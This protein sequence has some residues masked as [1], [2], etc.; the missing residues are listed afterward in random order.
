MNFLKSFVVGMVLLTLSIIQIPAQVL[1]SDN[2]DGYNTGALDKNLVGGPNA[3]PNGSGNPWF[4]P[5]PPNF[6]VVTAEYGVT[7]LSG[8]QM[9]RGKY[10]A[11]DFDQD[12]YNLAYR[13]G[14]GNSFSGNVSLS[15]NFYDP[16]GTGTGSA[17]YQDFNALTHYTVNATTTADQTGTGVG[18]MPGYQS[19]AGDQ[20]LSL[21]AYSATTGGDATKYQAR[22]VGVTDG[23]NANGWF[24]LNVTR[25]VGWHSAAIVL[26]S[27]NGTSTLVSFYLDGV[28][29]LHHALDT[30]AGVNYIE[31]NGSASSVSGWYDNLAFSQVPEPST[32][33]LL[34]CGGLSWLALRRRK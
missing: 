5:G 15:W 12:F 25:S 18:N 8:T 20:R 33:A 27:P 24:N 11:T 10:N 6:Q 14:G 16:L 32:V 1:F 7:P 17:N 19:G 26:G 30:T 31:M 3:A 23:I 2:F 34:L 4:G 29:V 28:D 9:I 21:G 22:G 13:L